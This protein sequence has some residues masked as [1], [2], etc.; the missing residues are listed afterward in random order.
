MTSDSLGGFNR[1]LPRSGLEVGS[2]VMSASEN[3]ALSVSSIKDNPQQ[4]IP[5]MTFLRR[6]PS[7]KASQTLDIV[8]TG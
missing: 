5:T 8:D 6:H 7:G 4:N 3:S 1:S 2:L